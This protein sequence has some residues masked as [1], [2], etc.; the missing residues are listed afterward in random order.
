VVELTDQPIDVRAVEAAVARPGAGALCTFQG[1]VRDDED[2]EP[3]RFLD[4]EAYPEMAL[5]ALEDVVAETRRRWPESRAAIVHRTGRLAVGEASV[6]IAIS[7]PHRAEAF[8]ACR[9]AIDTLKATVPIWKKEVGSSGGAWVEG[10]P[11]GPVE[12]VP[13]PAPSVEEE[14]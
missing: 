3:V 7:A 4:Y 12:S 11:P 8:A 5:P 2:G 6:V 14:R 10:T 13:N 9:W 1:V